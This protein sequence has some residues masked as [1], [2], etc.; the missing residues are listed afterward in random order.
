MKKISICFVSREYAHEKMGKTGG[1]GVFLKQYTQELKT[2][3][4]DIVVFSFGAKSVRFDDEGIHVIKI[5][6]L[7]GFNER[8]KSPFRR[9]RIPGYI[10]LKIILEYLN[11]TYISLYLSLFV[12]RRQFNLIEFHDYGGDAPFFVGRL[13]KIIRCHG[14]A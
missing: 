2:Y 3:N 12:L 5:K 14:S 8:I 4:F 11:R 10:S 6:D 1:I 9:Y 7:S 13:P